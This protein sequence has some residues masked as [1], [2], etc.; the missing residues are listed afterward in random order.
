MSKKIILSG[1]FI[2][3]ISLTAMSQLL[4]PDG[5]KLSNGFGSDPSYSSAGN[6]ISFGHSGHSEDFIGYQYNT[7]YFMDSPGGGD[8]TPPSIFVGGNISANNNLMA[9][10][11][12]GI[13]TAI[14]DGRLSIVG[15]SVSFGE[16]KLHIA[17]TN[18]EG[19]SVIRFGEEETGNGQAWLHRFNSDWTNG[20]AMWEKSS[21]G[22]YETVGSMNIGGASSFKVFTGST[23]TERLRIDN[24][25]NVGIGTTTPKEKLSVYGTI[26]SKEVK[27]E[28]NNWP[29]YVFFSDYAL[30]TLSETEVYIN[31]NHRLPNMPSAEEVAENGIALGEMNRLLV[32]KVE[33]LTLHLIKMEKEN[34]EL[35][36]LVRN[37]N[38][39]INVLESKIK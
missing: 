6:F 32:E 11:S 19:Y 26:R 3:Q 34:K 12:V 29:D 30:P 4:A 10:G 17:N 33:E 13:G 25:G 31:E 38:E 27:V 36:Q 39:K 9:N 2:I 35:L 15:A 21:I 20:E 37:Q 24:V 8:V 16:V 1:V 7:F 14:P 22:F 18:K 28:A 5:I 23:N